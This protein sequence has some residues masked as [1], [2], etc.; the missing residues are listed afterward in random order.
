MP[1]NRWT[2]VRAICFDLDGTLYKQLSL[3]VQMGRLLF[4]EWARGR[5]KAKDLRVLWS[6]RKN[7]ERARRL[8]ATPE[9]DAQV[10]TATAKENCRSPLEVV[11]IVERWLH[12]APLLILS[13]VRHPRLRQVLQRLRLRGYR[14]A[15]FSDYPIPSKLEA[16]D[17]PLDLFD[18]TVEA[19]E[20]E[21]SALKPHPK[22]FLEV[23]RRLDLRPPEVLYVGDRESVDGMG[24]R[25]AG[26][27]FVLYRPYTVGP[28]PGVIRKLDELERSLGTCCHVQELRNQ[29]DC[30]L[31]GRSSSVEFA[32]S[33]NLGELT[34]ESVKITDSRY[35][36]TA[37]LL[38]CLDCGFIRAETESARAIE[39][40]Y[41]ELVD[42]EYQ[43]SA[44]SR[45]RAFAGLLRR[46]R[47]L[48]PNARTL[49]DIGA[50]TGAFCAEAEGAGFRAEGVEPSGWAVA[51]GH[52]RYGVTLH[53][54]YFPHADLQA[55]KFDVVTMLDVIEHVSR[56]VEVLRAAH[57]CL[58]PGGLLLVVTPDIGSFV[59]RKMGARWWHLRPAHI[60]YFSQG[61]M[62]AALGAAGFSLE[63]VEPYT[64]WLPLSYLLERLGTYLPLGALNKLMR[65]N[66][67]MAWAGRTNIPVCL[68]DSRAYFAV[69]TGESAC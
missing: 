43:E 6:Y 26:M 62:M 40:L 8:G 53:E 23:C 60:G 54:G 65:A 19:D 59:A 14:L 58:A 39:P 4:R 44:A 57:A 52:R 66:K 13:T 46:I 42:A 31:C 50:S 25:S 22:G 56:P 51:E 21:V 10:L 12:Q 11:Q 41:R 67:W 27:Q 64:W 20:P 5:I 28:R 9:I 16:L 3:R 17:L 38:E 24:A 32:A 48:L 30:W 49:L 18:V 69:A 47:A 35:G 55:R 34:P 63:T 15:V 2:S 37:R 61:T 33:S 45:R 29:G 36:R 7:R 68:G 1:G